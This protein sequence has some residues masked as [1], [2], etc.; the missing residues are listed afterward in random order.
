VWTRLTGIL[1]LVAVYAAVIPLTLS[2]QAAGRVTLTERK[3]VR[4]ARRSRHAR[5]VFRNIEEQL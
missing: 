3:R 4:R 1:L 5:R 2:G